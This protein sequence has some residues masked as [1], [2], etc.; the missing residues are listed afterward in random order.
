VLL[1]VLGVW[2]YIDVVAMVMPMVVDVLTAGRVV[3]V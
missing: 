2:D 3:E 1:V